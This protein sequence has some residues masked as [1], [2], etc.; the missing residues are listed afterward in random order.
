MLRRGEIETVNT[1]K[2][3]CTSFFLLIKYA[4]E[5]NKSAEQILTWSK[6]KYEKGIFF[7]SEGLSRFCKNEAV[8]QLLIFR[9]N[10]ARSHNG[11]L[12]EVESTNKE[13]SPV[14]VYLILPE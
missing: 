6:R 3:F 14:C 5:K 9:I 10:L 4:L 7:G 8:E 12:D 13:S 1:T 2:D 11:F